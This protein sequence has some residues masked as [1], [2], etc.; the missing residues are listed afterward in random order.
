MLRNPKKNNQLR[1]IIVAAN[2]IAA[3]FEI[4]TFSNSNGF[5][6]RVCQIL[7]DDIQWNDVKFVEKG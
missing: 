5:V 4:I 3:A 7:S 2:I 6:V 1:A